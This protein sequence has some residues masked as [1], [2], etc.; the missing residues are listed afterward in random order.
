MD[1]FTIIED[2]TFFIIVF[3]YSRSIFYYLGM[4]FDGDRE[5]ILSALTE[6]ARNEIIQYKKQKRAYV[7]PDGSIRYSVN[8]DTVKFVCHNL[9]DVPNE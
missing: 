2:N 4:T 8:Y 1:I 7:G 6:E 9:S 3:S 5:N